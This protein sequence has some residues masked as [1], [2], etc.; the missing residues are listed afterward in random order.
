MPFERSKVDSVVRSRSGRGQG[1]A[2]F[3]LAVVALLGCAMPDRSVARLRTRASTTASDPS[4][5]AVRPGPARTLPF[6]LYSASASAFPELA[7][8]G[9]TIVGPWYVPAPD[10]ALLDAASESGLSVVFPVGD[11]R[12]RD[13][14]V[15]DLPHAEVQATI[16]ARVREV[17]DHPAIVAWYVLPEEVRDWDARELGYLE[18]ATEAIRAADP[19]RRPILSYQPNHRGGE[20]LAR[21]LAPLDIATKGAYTNFAGHR[22]TRAWVPWSIDELERT[23]DRDP[24]L[25]AEM[26]QDPVDADRATIAAWVRHDV[27]AALIA[28]AKGVLVYSGHRR[29]GFSAYDDYLGAYETVARELNGPLALADVLLAG[30]RCRAAAVEIVHGATEVTFEGNERAQHMPALGRLELVHAGAHWSWLANSS[31]APLTVRAEAWRGSQAVVGAE[32]RVDDVTFALPAWGVA[33]VK[34]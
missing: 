17:V 8:N 6:G 19:Q 28:G 3:F 34:R 13:T 32:H 33:V 14:G 20:H 10:R 16:G 18:A 15:F 5:D 11:P 24:W 30:K 12:G 26:F 22:E 7:R 21:V 4:A 2:G 23:S 1:G 31:P 25:V 27:Y 29:P 9:F